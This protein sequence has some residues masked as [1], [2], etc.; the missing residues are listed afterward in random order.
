MTYRALAAL[1][2]PA[3]S[4]CSTADHNERPPSRLIEGAPLYDVLPLDGIPAIDDPQFVDA[5]QAGAYM[6][7]D[8]PVIGVVGSDGTAKCYSAWHLDGHEI[9]NDTLD[10]QS[11]AVTW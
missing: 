11:I 6:A 8:E 10:G 5:E 3:L 2:L 7:D 4:A 9:V 1:C